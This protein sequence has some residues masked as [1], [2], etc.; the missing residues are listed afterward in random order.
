ME[1]VPVSHWR[2]KPVVV[3]AWQF[4]PA[5]QREELPPWIDRRWFYEDPGAGNQTGE[6]GGPPYMLIPTPGGTLRAD[7]TDWIIRSVK[8]DVYPCR[9]DVFEATYEPA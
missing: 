9:A 2:R 6:V 1:R 8:G 7:L 5:G 3:E 4:M